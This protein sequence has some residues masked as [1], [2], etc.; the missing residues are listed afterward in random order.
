[1]KPRARRV[2]I[3]AAVLGAGVVGVAVVLNWTTVRDHVEAWHFQLT[4]D[5]QAL[6]PNPRWQDEVET[7]MPT[8]RLP[9]YLADCSGVA[10]ICTKWERWEE[11]KVFS[12]LLVFE[13]ETETVKT[14]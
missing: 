2:T 7:V 14:Y 4:E 5:T 3:A 10:V 8:A 12:P 6:V 1:M 13:G 9:Q 11:G